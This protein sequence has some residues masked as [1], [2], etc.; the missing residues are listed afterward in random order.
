MSAINQCW[1]FMKSGVSLAEK[2]AWYDAQYA[3]MIAGTYERKA[4]VFKS[5]SDPLFD[6]EPIDGW[7]PFE[8]YRSWGALGSN[9]V[10]SIDLPGLIRDLEKT[11][12]RHPDYDVSRAGDIYAICI[13]DYFYTNFY[14]STQGY[15]FVVAKEHYHT[16]NPHAYGQAANLF[17]LMSSI[18]SFAFIA[19][20]DKYETDVSRLRT[21][22]GKSDGGY[23]DC[24]I[25]SVNLTKNGST[26]LSASGFDS[27]SAWLSDS[28]PLM[29][30]PEWNVLQDK[31]WSTFRNGLKPSGDWVYP[32]THCGIY[33]PAGQE[34]WSNFAQKTEA[35]LYVFDVFKSK[36][37]EKYCSRVAR[38]QA[39]AVPYWL[40]G[41]TSSIDDTPVT[42]ANAASGSVTYVS[43]TSQAYMRPVLN[44]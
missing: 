23:A 12:P 22:Y 41:L 30:I 26:Y 20:K 36:N 13:G 27:G 19:V 9:G 34:L 38:S 8:K 11:D 28:T 40:R 16:L 7:K 6:F 25:G 3:A 14:G 1:Y 17:T 21:A 37:H 5:L 31:Q 4:I 15:L 39:V 42:M 43:A 2:K 24:Y 35:D 18:P 33:I 32:K 29:N 10:Y 44:I